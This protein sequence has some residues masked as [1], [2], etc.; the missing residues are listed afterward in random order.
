M[1]ECF[2]LERI[3]KLKEYFTRV[4]KQTGVLFMYIK[5]R[6]FNYGLFVLS[7]LS[8]KLRHGACS[9][10]CPGQFCVTWKANLQNR[11]RAVCHLPSRKLCSGGR[12]LHDANIVAINKLPVLGL[13]SKLSRTAPRRRLLR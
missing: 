8:T 6:P 9:T 4:K 3:K 2:L 1:F 7:V 11:A 13:N 5:K 10:G 12:A